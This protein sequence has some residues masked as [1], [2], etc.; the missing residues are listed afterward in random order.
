[1]KNYCFESI[2]SYKDK[3]GSLNWLVAPLCNSINS[4][5]SISDLRKCNLQRGRSINLALSHRGRSALRAVDLED[6]V[7]KNSITMKGRLLHNLPNELTSVLY[8]EQTNQVI[9]TVEIFQ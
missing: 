1:M 5:P 4:V 6:E 2:S 8:D 9:K 7:L 3:T